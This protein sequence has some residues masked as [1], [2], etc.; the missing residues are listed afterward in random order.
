MFDLQWIDEAL[1]VYRELEQQANEIKSKREK[2]QKIKSSKQEGL[3]K[4]VQKT[5]RHLRENPRHPGFETR[6]YSSLE[7]HGILPKKFLKH[8]P[9]II[10]LQHIEFFAVM[11]LKNANYNYHY[12]GTSIA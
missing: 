1:R 9:K 3:F 8:I 12:Y 10:L 2:K 11:G 6:S 4:Q 5:L 7:H